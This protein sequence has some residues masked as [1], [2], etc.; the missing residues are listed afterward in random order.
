MG[1]GFE[2]IELHGV[3]EV[4]AG[5]ED[6]RRIAGMAKCTGHGV[7]AEAVEMHAH[8]G[9][10]SLGD[11]G[12]HV[13]IARDQH[14]I[15]NLV[16]QAGDNHVCDEPSIDGLLRPSVTP[17]NELTCAQLHTIDRAQ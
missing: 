6:C 2:D 15:G 12:Q 4:L 10:R 5:I 3:G 7:P 16:A 11:A 9:S 14:D 13:R 8:T 17:F 1:L